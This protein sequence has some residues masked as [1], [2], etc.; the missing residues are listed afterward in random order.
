MG[1][2]WGLQAVVWEGELSG[3]QFYNQR[4]S[5]EGEKHLLPHPWVDGRQVSVISSSSRLGRR[6]L[7]SLHCQAR[8]VMALWKN[9]FRSQYNEG[10]SFWNV[11]FPWI[12]FYVCREHVL[13]VINT[14]LS[15]QDTDLATIALLFWVMSHAFDAWFYC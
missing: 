11:T 1:C 7:F 13:G 12:I 3:L 15:E 8:T 4:K 14:E 9:N 5:A 6:V 10:L 2:L